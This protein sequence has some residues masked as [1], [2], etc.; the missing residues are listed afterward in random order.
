MLKVMESN[1]PTPGGIGEPSPS[2]PVLPSAPAPTVPVGTKPPVPAPFASPIAP[3]P[4]A[5]GLEP[6][7]P[8]KKVEPQF[9]ERGEVPPSPPPTP[10]SVPVSFGRGARLPAGGLARLKAILKLFFTLFVFIL[11][12]VAGSSLLKLDLY[13][14]PF[15]KTL[16]PQP[17]KEVTL[18]YWGLWE[19]SD[20]MN[21]LFSE[22]ITAYTKEHPNISLTIN[23]EKR[24]FGTLEQHK[25][26][27][28]TR[29]RQG[30]APDILRLHNGWVKEFASELA[31]VPTGVMSGSDYTTA[32]YPV[33]LSSAKVGEGIYA[34]P[35]EYDGI[36]LFY[37]KTLLKGVNVNSALSTWEG[38]RRQAVK[39]TQWEE[40]D[41]EKKILRA[42]AAFGA[43]NNI[44]HAADLLS[45]LF[46]Q[47]GVDPLTELKAQAAADA[48]TF[49][50]NF[51]KVD[52]NW[53][54]TLPFSINAFANGQVAMIF[55]PSWRALDIKNLNPQLEFAAVPVPQ[56]P[57]A[58]Q[59]GV[60]WATFWMEAV[61]K[62][63]Q[64]PEIAWRLLKFLS[65]E[66]QQRK[67][68]SAISQVRSFG[69]PY[70]RPS[71]AESL[72]THAIL[73]AL[74]TGAPTAVS[75]KTTDLSGNKAYVDALKQA[76]ADVLAGK[77]AAKALETA[78]ATINQLEG[79]AP[80]PEE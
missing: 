17:R 54:E 79:V 31:P 78:Q 69:E 77:D 42:G 3:H 44:S 76:I 26:T 22:F 71:L 73:G 10:P 62:D 37:N 1:L 38:F 34:I 2:Q 80:P 61:S 66:E 49:Y 63:S 6:S 67:L 5:S 36:V 40:N 53:D 60:H 50:T 21:P 74:L 70:S 48:L 27:L 18:T 59:A 15:L 29:L 56:L 52:H 9:P 45:L 7:L 51:V 35:L 24:T 72:K 11:I 16:I 33:A 55:G 30:T 39:L 32:F 13:Q 47:S 28:L 46:V 68:Y 41:P 4:V 12:I 19:N 75:G 58:P 65:E 57:S 25:E 23:Y 43:A 64:N 20:L 8:P 14:I